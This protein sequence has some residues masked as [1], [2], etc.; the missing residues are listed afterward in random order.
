MSG[1]S[2]WS[3]IKRRKGA[4]DAVKAKIFTKIGRE[5]SVAVKSGGSDPAT[6][7]R[8][9]DAIAKA[10][11]NNIP[12]DNIMRSIK[13]AS[14][15]LGSINYE[16]MTYEGYGI[17]GVAVIIEALTDNKNRTAGDVRHLLDKYGGGLGTNGCVAFMFN[18]QG[19]IIVAK[20][21]KSEDEVM[22]LCLDL[23]AEDFK[24]EDDYYEIYT[25]PNDLRTVRENLEKRGLSVL[26]AEADK[27][28]SNTVKLSEEQLIKFEKMIEL[29]EELDDIQNVYHNCEYDASV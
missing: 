1:H 2:R 26:S 17:G 5:I 16:S 3:N 14:G 28:P 22:M 23:G 11:D 15:E 21:G 6:N 24:T 20:D 18:A 29:L 7:S 13:K 19:V 9:A 12:N 27:I 4:A 8:L 10:K 25:N